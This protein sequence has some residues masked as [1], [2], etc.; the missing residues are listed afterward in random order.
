MSVSHP[1]SVERENNGL[2]E[3]ATTYRFLRRMPQKLPSSVSPRFEPRR[4][5]GFVV[6]LRILHYSDFIGEPCLELK[7]RKVP[8]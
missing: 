8:A 4:W 1:H 3:I 6:T 7:S 5:F 2:W